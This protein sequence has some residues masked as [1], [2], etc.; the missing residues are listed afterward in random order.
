MR[1]ISIILVTA[2]LVMVAFGVRETDTFG[3]QVQEFFTDRPSEEA[4]GLLI[5]GGIAA[6]LGLLGLFVS[7]RGRK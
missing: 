2:G 1:T 3:S 7:S 5:G 4:S 6:G